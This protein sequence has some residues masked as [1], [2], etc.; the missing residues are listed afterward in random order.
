MA[1]RAKIGDIV[2]ILTSK[3][4]AYAQFTHKHN[5]YGYLLAVFKGFYKSLPGDFSQIVSMKPQFFV[6]FPLQ[7]ALN[8]NLV[9]VV[10]NVPVAV[11]NKSFP[12]FRT[13]HR[14]SS[15]E[16]VNWAIWDGEKSERLGRK[17]NEKEKTYSMRGIISAPLLVE[18]I[19]KGYRPETHD[20]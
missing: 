3:G 10:S 8:Q 19:E 11:G 12:I 14:S 13:C 6:F 15:G 9:S 7:S 5:E 18:R 20:I 16:K 2:Q 4:I 17:L 1:K